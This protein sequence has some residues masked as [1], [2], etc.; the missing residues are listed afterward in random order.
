RRSAQ[1]RQRPADRWGAPDGILVEIE[2]EFVGAAFE[3]WIIGTH[4]LDRW[5]H[6]NRRL[7]FR[8]STERACAN[9]PSARANSVTTGARRRTPA[10][11][12]SCTLM[13]FTKSVTERPPRVRATPPVG[14]TW[15]VP[16]A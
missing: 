2:A 16:L 3:R 8:T 13:H 11:D 1:L 10:R 14:R 4:P 12:T 9:S 5:P 6:P 15:F 7:H